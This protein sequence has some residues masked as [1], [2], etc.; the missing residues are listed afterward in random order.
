VILEERYADRID[1]ALVSK[2]P[3]FDFARAL[4]LFSEPQ[5]S[6]SGVSDRAYVHS[7][8]TVHGTATVYPFVFIGE[9]AE[10]GENSVVFPGCYVGERSVV[11]KD[12]ILYPNVTL[13][14]DT[15]IGDRV[16]VNAGAVL[17]SDGFGFAPSEGGMEKIPQMGNVVIEDDVEIGAN[18]TIDRAVLAGTV[19]GKG[20][21]IDNLV[22]VGHNVTVGEGSI[23]VAQVGVSGSTT[24]GKGVTL[25]GQVGVSG[26]LN[27]GDGAIIGPQSGVAKNIPANAVMGGTPAMERG[28]FMRYLALAPKLPEMARTVRRLEKEIRELKKATGQ[29]ED[30]GG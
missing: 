21:K 28:T 30:N 4:T 6:L 8:A 23:L 2:N 13:M 17:G 1:T 16:V 15:V 3:Y 10:V 24:I 19:I 25:A 5:G 27:I 7:G 29:G 11:G 9:N 20:S 26:H 12:C 18:T 14:A 22:Q